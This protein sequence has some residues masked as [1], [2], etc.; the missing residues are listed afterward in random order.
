MPHLH[1]GLKENGLQNRSACCGT[2]RLREYSA[3]DKTR[4]KELEKLRAEGLGGMGQDGSGENG[5][6][7]AAAE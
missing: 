7:R 5:P 2:M 6:Q 3:A 4:E 1:L